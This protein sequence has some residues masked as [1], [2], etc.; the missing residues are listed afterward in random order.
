[1]ALHNYDKLTDDQ[2]IKA[3]A[4]KAESLREMINENYSPFEDNTPTAIKKRKDRCEHS[5][6][7]FIHTYLPH[8]AR[9][10]SAKFHPKMDAGAWI[11]NILV[12][13]KGSR[14]T[15]KTV[16]L[17][18]T[19]YLMHA[20]YHKLTVAGVGSLTEREA[21]SKLLPVRVELEENER[22]INDFGNLKG[23]PWRD[24]EFCA[25]G[26]TFFAK[27]VGQ[28]FRGLLRYFRIQDI[29]FDDVFD[30]KAANSVIQTKN[31]LEWI[32]SEAIP[33]MDSDGYHMSLFG[34]PLQLG[35]VMDILLKETK[36]DG[37]PTYHT[38]ESCLDEGDFKSAWP[39]KY[40][41]NFLKNMYEQMGSLAY[42]K[43]ILLKVPDASELYQQAWFDRNHFDNYNRPSND[44]LFI[45]FI[46]DPSLGL[47]NGCPSAI[48]TL[49]WCATIAKFYM[50]GCKIR[51]IR[52]RKQV[53]IMAEIWK[54]IPKSYGYLE[55][56]G[57]Q[58][59]LA[60]DIKELCPLMPLIVEVTTDSKDGRLAE[61][62]SLV[63][64]D[65]ILF[66]PNL[67]DTQIFIDQCVFYD[68]T[69]YV[70]GP[71]GAML[72]ARN[73][74]KRLMKMVSGWTNS[75][76]RASAKALRGYAHG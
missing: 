27:G 49:A 34:Q 42:N 62:S 72:L 44:K 40:P 33:A 13:Q 9:T 3:M 4:D 23:A 66:D 17:L 36:V 26:V 71:D 25:N 10:K 18:I 35:S 68:G 19:K 64:S 28:S 30:S 60:E 57:F 47:P 2:F 59:L 14:G 5:I 61:F 63:E 1:M 74:R 38:I 45:A 52:P 75:K 53:Q 21:I 65:M 29:A 24:E 58:E 31:A 69:G 41:D 11:K 6:E 32:R 56:N 37:S 55:S 43:E 50:I 20:C 46:D 22:I 7:N 8:Y 39:E 15:A 16:R 70:D 73:M 54:K 51:R 48:I 76:R 67:E 12:L